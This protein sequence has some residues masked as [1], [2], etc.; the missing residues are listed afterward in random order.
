MKVKDRM[1]EGLKKFTSYTNKLK[2]V[3]ER[4]AEVFSSSTARDVRN[5]KAPTTGGFV[6]TDKKL[7]G[8]VFDPELPALATSTLRTIRFSRES[9]DVLKIATRLLD[10]PDAK[11][12]EVGEFCFDRTLHALDKK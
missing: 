11:P 4:R 9:K 12:G 7:G 6:R 2:K 5:L 3:P 10:N 8:K 1:R